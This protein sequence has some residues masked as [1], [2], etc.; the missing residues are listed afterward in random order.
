MIITNK[1]NLPETLVKAITH[2]LKPRRG[3]SVTDLIGPPRIVQLSRRHFD[4][5]EEDAVE[6]IWLLLGSAVHYILEKGEVPESL[7]EQTLKAKVNGTIITGRPDLLHKNCITDYKVTSSWSMVF[8]PNGREDW[9]TQLNLYRYLYQVNKFHIDRLQICAILRDW[10]ERKAQAERD[11]PQSPVIMIDI[12]IWGDIIVER[13]IYEQVKLH[14]DAVNLPDDDLPFCFNKDMWAKPTQYALMN[15]RKKSAVALFGTFEEA[16]DRLDSIIEGR[17]YYI[18]ER[19]GRRPR[20]KF[21][22]PVSSFCNQY[23][24]YKLNREQAR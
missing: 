10:Q 13:Y 11:Y 6:R 9:H 4:E 23:T 21:Y 14:T 5:L 24:E 18:E 3:F 2:D 22:C 16:Q 8:S 12:P 17:G 19:P 15:K 1:H 20:C 7:K